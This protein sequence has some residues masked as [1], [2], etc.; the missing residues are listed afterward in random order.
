MPQF[1]PYLLPLLLLCLPPF[2]SGQSGGSP[3]FPAERLATLRQ[4]VVFDAPPPAPAVES[5]GPV[6]DLSAYRRPIIVGVSVGL[7]GGLLFLLYRIARDLAR[8]RSDEPFPSS[9]AEAVDVTEIR[10]EEFVR[11]G[12]SPHLLQRAEAAG[13]YDVAVRLLYLDLLNRLHRADLIV[14]RPHFSNRDYRQQLMDS[15]LYAPFT[16]SV[17]AYERFW[18]GKHRI[19]RLSYRLTRQEFT[20]LT[21]RVR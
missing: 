15:D 20:D 2:A 13:Q 12:L 6:I 7:I 5:T 3:V 11:Q 19:D 14:Y 17:R 4:E 21:E 18:Y 10:E 9:A 16:K 8:H 1:V